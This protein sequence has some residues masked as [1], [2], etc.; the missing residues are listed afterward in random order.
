MNRAGSIEFYSECSYVVDTEEW[1]PGFVHVT[2]W[3]VRP[4]E[5]PDD[6]RHDRECDG[7]TVVGRDDVNWD[8][9]IPASLRE[10][11]C[12]TRLIKQIEDS[13]ESLAEGE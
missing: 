3:E 1:E 2:W 5:D 9:E 4:G 12:G 13:T 6:V 11:D 7:D 8:L 10:G